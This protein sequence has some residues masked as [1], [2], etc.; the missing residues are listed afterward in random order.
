MSF[1]VPVLQGLGLG[2][3]FSLV[4]IAIVAPLVVW[5]DKKATKK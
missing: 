2:L 4:A 5:L 1:L 3:V